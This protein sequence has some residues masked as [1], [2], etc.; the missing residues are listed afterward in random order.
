[1]LYCFCRSAINAHFV[2][3]FFLF[4]VFVIRTM[5]LLLSTDFYWNRCTSKIIYKIK[6]ARFSFSFHIHAQSTI[7]SSIQYRLHTLEII[8]QWN[9]LIIWMDINLIKCLDYLEF[10]IINICSLCIFYSVLWIL[11]L[12][13]SS[14]DFYVSYKWLW[15]SFFYQK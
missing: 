13:W 15:N 12:E 11:W 2:V 8:P 5:F 4:M 10:R 3:V 6:A 9:W 1:M 7:S 14:S